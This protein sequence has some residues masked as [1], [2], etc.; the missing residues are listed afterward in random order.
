MLYCN[1]QA[2]R[3]MDN[4][5]FQGPRL[6]TFLDFIEKRGQC[7]YLP[8]YQRYFTWKTENIQRVFEDVIAGIRRFDNNQGTSHNYVT[9]IGSM[10]FFY[11]QLYET[12]E[13]QIRADVPDT[14]YSVVDGQQRLTALMLISVLL[15]NYIRVLYEQLKNEMSPVLKKCCNERLKQLL[16][17]IEDPQA[18]DIDDQ[19]IYYPRMIRA[20]DDQW[21]IDKDK[22]FYDSPLSYLISNYGLHVRN[23]TTDINYQHKPPAQS[24]TS[25]SAHAHH[26]KFTN[27]LKQTQRELHTIFSGKA[28]EDTASQL[29]SL[30]D[31]LCNNELLINTFNLKYDQIKTDIIA[32]EDLNHCMLARA[33]I[34]SAYILKNIQFITLITRD[35]NQAFDIFESLNTTGQELTALETFRPEIVRKEG[36]EHYSSSNSKK[37]I[38]AID[39]FIRNEK[40]EAKLSKD[41]IVNFALAEDGYKLSNHLRDQR[42][43]LRQRYS[44]CDDKE[45]RNEFTLHLM[46]VSQVMQ[47]FWLKHGDELFTSPDLYHTS[48]IKLVQQ[49]KEADK[50]GEDTETIIDN[51]LAQQSKELRFCLKYLSESNHAICRA[52]IARFHH[53][54]I[55]SKSE[56]K[57]AR[58]NELV[59]TIKVI[60]AWYALWRG[61]RDS[62]DGLDSHYR[63]ILAGDDSISINMP[64]LCRVQKNTDQL[65]PPP[66]VDAVKKAFRYYLNKGG[67]S[68]K[69]IDSLEDWLSFSSTLPIYGLRKATAKFLLLVASHNSTVKDGI[70][71]DC[72]DNVSSLIDGDIWISTDYGSFEL[73]IPVNNNDDGETEQLYRLGNLT[74][75]PKWAYL[76][77]EKH[78]AW[79][80]KQ[81]IYKL[82]SSDTDDELKK[83]LEQIT[84]LGGNE[85]K[86]FKVHRYLPITKEISLRDKFTQDSI[87]P[88]GEMIGT[89]VWKILAEQ[90]LE[91]PSS[92]GLDGSKSSQQ[93]SQR[94]N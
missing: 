50:A 15:H 67:R 81:P 13:P 39:N 10:T 7:F 68:G 76:I 5:S 36:L 72:N 32:Y 55:K 69:R 20:F 37:H 79:H 11:D 16:Q 88:H 52:L 2:K 25:E 45:K 60:A 17:V 38:D 71:V 31:M 87:V 91:F 85:K 84:F 14:V 42:D 34:V 9:F 94:A 23:N 61:T 51:E 47:H 4:S 57:L 65:N 62:T 64:P 66:S 29:P 46:C 77:L 63:D 86:K 44:R 43:Y 40:D 3:Y 12:I 35:E 18:S 89:R 22:E 59:N 70:I 90:W 8:S 41:I 53:A 30:I 19:E 24:S 93:S 75:V 28:N 48:I 6:V 33:L 26:K 78:P 54:V 49:S 82:L 83:L 56:N 58:I 80:E 1:E 74:L 21:S 27:I 73:I 92:K